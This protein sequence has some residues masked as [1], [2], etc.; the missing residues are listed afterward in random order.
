[1]RGAPT[2]SATIK[3]VRIQFVHVYTNGLLFFPTF[4]IKIDMSQTR[5]HSTGTGQSSPVGCSRRVHK[6]VY[7]VVK[8]VIFVHY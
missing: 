3:P 1:M 8:R 6:I 7:L 4:L 5:E 2:T